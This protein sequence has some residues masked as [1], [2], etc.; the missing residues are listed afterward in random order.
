[1]VLYIIGLGLGDEKDITVRGL[2][3]VRKC[4][5]VYLEYYTSILGLDHKSLEKFYGVE[6]RV[7]D[8]NM[9]ESNAEEIYSRAATEDIGFLVVG[10]PLCATTHNDIIL[11]ARK[12]NI[13][14]QV[15]HNAS[16]MSASASSGLQLYQFG[17]TVSIPLFEDNWKPDSFYDRIRYNKAGGMHT[18]CL[19]DIKVKEPDYSSMSAGKS[20]YSYIMIL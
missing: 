12:E 3:L 9:V 5:V 2:E 17:Y 1:M 11:R 16:V 8:R 15:V 10:D 18:L 6:V 13:E 7:A 4:K 20:R 19:L 14:V